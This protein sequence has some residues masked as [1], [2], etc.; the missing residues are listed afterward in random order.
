MSDYSNGDYKT[1]DDVI[2][3]INELANFLKDNQINPK[4]HSHLEN[5]FLK[6]HQFYE[7]YKKNP[8]GEQDE[9][10]RSSFVGLFELYKWI[11]SVKNCKEFSKLKNHL[12]LL[13]EASPRINSCIKMHNP[14]TGKQDDKTNKFFEAIIGMWAVKIGKNVELDDPI[15]SSSGNNPDV[16]F[17]FSGKRIGIAC[18]TLRGKS[19]RT[20]INNFLSAAKQIERAKCDIGYIAINAMNILPHSKIRDKIFN[21]YIEPIKILSDDIIRLYQ[22]IRKKAEDEILYIFR[23]KK[24]QPTVLTFIHSIY[25]SEIIKTNSLKGT[26]VHD[27]K[28]PGIDISNDIKLL[29]LVNEFIHN[30]L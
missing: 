23:G 16:M 18:K 22:E 24:V 26:F 10:D 20:V 8:F 14:V 5:D 9:E 6:A 21:S 13:I 2:K 1:Y 4:L 29:N 27:F 30:R 19:E 7:N 11:F 3:C 12:Q 28:I 17:E 25:K 15:K